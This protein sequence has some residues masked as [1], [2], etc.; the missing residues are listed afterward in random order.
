[1]VLI[2]PGWMTLNLIPYLPHSAARD[3]WVWEKQSEDTQW[4]NS[5]LSHWLWLIRNDPM[6]SRDIWSS[7]LSDITASSA[8]ISQRPTRLWGLSHRGMTVAQ[9][10]ALWSVWK[11]SK[12]IQSIKAV[13]NKSTL[14]NRVITKKAKIG[15]TAYV[16]ESVIK[17]YNFSV[18]S[19]PLEN[20]YVHRV[21]MNW[22]QIYYF[23]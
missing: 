8:I 21:L 20:I 4:F 12:K 9:G 2:G 11:A 18:E 1:M 17:M 7:Y 5:D 13:F 16:K 19:K 10:T 6:Y 23:I 15:T 22:H 14:S 3:L